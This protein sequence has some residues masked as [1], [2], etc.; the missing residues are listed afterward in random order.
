M[1]RKTLETK[2]ARVAALR[3]GATTPHER[4]AAAKAHDRI[5]QRLNTMPRV[6][7]VSLDQRDPYGRAPTLADERP[8]PTTA[9]IRAVLRSWQAGDCS[10]HAGPGA[11]GCCVTACAALI[12]LDAA[13]PTPYQPTAAKP[14][15]PALAL[16][17]PSRSV[18]PPRRPPRAAS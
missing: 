10:R 9:E 18:E 16:D 12:W 14:R 7:T 5:Q 4:R 11:A 1:N 8:M 3:D 2:L 13:A 15:P 6:R 17:A